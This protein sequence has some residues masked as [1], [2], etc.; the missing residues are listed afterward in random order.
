MSGVIGALLVIGQL[1]VRQIMKIP[2]ILSIFLISGGVLFGAKALTEEAVDKLPSPPADAKAG[3]IHDGVQIGLWTQKENFTGD[4]IRNVWIFARKTRSSAITIGVGGRLYKD[5]FLYI[6]D[7]T[8]KVTKIPAK[9][10]VDGM[11]DPSAFAGGISGWLAKLPKG[12]YDLVWKTEKF[13]SN[14]LRINIQNGE[15]GDAPNDGPAMPVDN[16]DGSGG[17]RHR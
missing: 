1:V 15:P 6:T 12:T 2:S 7:A 4:E 13:K 11:V 16:S 8:K 10:P 5:S 14:T 17:G 3:V 9:G